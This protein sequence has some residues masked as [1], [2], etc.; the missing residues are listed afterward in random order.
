MAT[1]MGA[2]G[3]TAVGPLGRAHIYADIYTNR[4][5]CASPHSQ[6]AVRH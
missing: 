5:P 3:G 1:Q 4:R 2:E 6:G